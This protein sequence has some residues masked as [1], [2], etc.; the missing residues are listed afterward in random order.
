MSLLI[1]RFFFVSLLL[2]CFTSIFLLHFDYFPFVFASD[3]VL[4]KQFF[5]FFISFRFFCLFLVH[6]R[7]ILLVFRFDGKQAKSSI[8]LASK[9]N[10]IFASISI[11][12]S[13]A[14][15]R[16]HPTWGPPFRASITVK[17]IPPI[18]PFVYT[19]NKDR[20]LRE[21]PHFL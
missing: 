9:R 18:L 11:F 2:V 5:G 17:I 15:M 3:F 10:K 16:A 6:F 4:V 8:F 1:L 20:H 13:E 14:K 12:A 21:S 7:F 19:N